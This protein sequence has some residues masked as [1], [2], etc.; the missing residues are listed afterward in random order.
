MRSSEPVDT[1]PCR[2]DLTKSPHEPGGT[3][4]RSTPLDCM[5][6]RE[7][8]RGAASHLPFGPHPSP[9][10]FHDARH[11]RET[12]SRAFELFRAMQPLENSEE[13]VGIGHVEAY[14]VVTHEMCR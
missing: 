7:V 10:T 14:P 11:H 2:S 9:V 12:D 3:L 13:L 5:L 4:C 1:I 6:Q 8:D